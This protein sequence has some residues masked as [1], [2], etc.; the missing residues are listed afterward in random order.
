VSSA[1]DEWLA[2]DEHLANG[3]SGMRA[4]L[5]A[6][7]T[8]SKQM[9]SRMMGQSRGGWRGG[10]TASIHRRCSAIMSATV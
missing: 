1:S 10:H 9:A 6:W 5:R 2:E 3:Q 4:A 8:P 7:S